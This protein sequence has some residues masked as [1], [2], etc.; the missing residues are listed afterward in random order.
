MAEHP[1]PVVRLSG[2]RHAY[3]AV[4]ALDGWTWSSPPGG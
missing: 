1:G 2:L 4:M 3:R